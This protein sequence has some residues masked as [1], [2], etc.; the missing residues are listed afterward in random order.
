MPVVTSQLLSGLTTVFRSLF[1]DQFLAASVPGV[2]EQIAME[3]PSTTDTESYNWFGTVPAMRE[4]IGD[5]K[6]SGL[7][8]QTYSLQNKD[9][10]SSIEVDRNAIE[11]DRIGI[12]RPRISQLASEARRHQEAGMIAA[13][14]A[15]NTATGL[16]YD[17]Q[18]FFDTDHKDPGA[19]FQTNQSNKLTGTGTT[20]AQ[21]RADYDAARAAMFNLKDGEGR[22]M[23]ITPSHVLVPP[24]LEGAFRQLL[25][26]DMVPDASAGVTNIWKGSAGLLVSPYLTDANDWYLLALN[27]PVKPFIFQNRRPVQFTALDSPTAENVFRRKKFQYGVDARYAFGYAFWQMAI[28]TTNT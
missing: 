6:F 14:I 22:P 18:Q 24:A 12:I 25:N 13:V 4:W 26:A 28:L 15:G 10:E 5:R 2:R 3:V 9:W 11:D 17:G 21:I 8:S 20:A 7:D 23:G 27:Q 1:E 16:A 19:T